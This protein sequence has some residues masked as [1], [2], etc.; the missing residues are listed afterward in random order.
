MIPTFVY[1]T[2]SSR[3]EALKIARHMVEERLAAC[4]NILPGITSVYW[5]EGKV[6]EEGEVSLIL[7]TRRDLV[8]PLVARVKELHSYTCPCVVALPLSGGNPAFL[9]W[10]VKE[11]KAS[12]A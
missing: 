3:D 5:W 12:A 6:Q 4:A 8:D 2:A 10:I 9:D 1:V 7:K 11:T